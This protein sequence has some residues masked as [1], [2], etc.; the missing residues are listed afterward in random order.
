M[1]ERKRSTGHRNN[2]HM[3]L[4]RM[5]ATENGFARRF[6]AVDKGCGD[7]RTCR[8]RD[9]GFIGPM[10]DS[11]SKT[12]RMIPRPFPRI[13]AINTRH[14]MVANPFGLTNLNIVDFA[15]R[16]IM[17]TKNQKPHQFLRKISISFYQVWTCVIAAAIDG[18]RS[19]QPK[20]R[21]H[22]L[23]YT[24]VRSFHCT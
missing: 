8:R 23:D 10:A 18:R 2:R 3:E 6:P 22:P 11:Y 16:R 24:T 19:R 17:T 13:P 5:S 1:N 15:A 7:F 14:G 20:G 12:P 4:V 9:N 21:D